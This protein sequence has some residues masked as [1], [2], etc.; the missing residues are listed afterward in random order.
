[1]TVT[2]E[3]SVPSGKTVAPSSKSFAHRALILGAFSNKSVI[4]N[5]D[6]SDDIKATLSCLEKLGAK[7]QIDGNTVITG[8]ISPQN[9]AENT[10]LFCSESGSTLRFLIPVCLT[11][12]KKINLSGTKRLLERPLSEYEKICKESGLLFEKSDDKVTVCGN[13]KNGV[14]SLSSEISSQYIT[15]FLLGLSLINGESK[16]ILNG[17]INSKPY[18]DI[19]LYMLEKFGVKTDFSGNI[20]TVFGRKSIENIEYTVEGDASNSA[21][22]EAF[23]L[24]GGDV[25]I[26]DLDDNTRQGDYVYKKM[27]FELQNGKRSFDLRNCPDLAPVMFSASCLFGKCEFTGT[28]RLKYKESDRCSSM[29]QELEKLGVSVQIEENKVIIEPKEIH[30]P[31]KEFSGHN[32]HRIV[33]A[34]SLLCAKYGGT[35]T[36]AEAVNKSF[37]LF[38]E[39]L[40][41]I[42]V[43]IKENA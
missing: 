1:M 36:G 39:K 15:G 30:S 38:F 26:L 33:M 24:L 23:G 11:L 10:E 4:K 27:F 2:I 29:K 8:G 22:L 9:I 18:I 13:L 28:N 20:I 40:I 5:V 21:Y 35:I 42:G 14:F 17:E 19:T 31:Q 34:L 43:K 41:E 25:K 7:V 3:K 37:P 12:G 6:F 32:D 16:I